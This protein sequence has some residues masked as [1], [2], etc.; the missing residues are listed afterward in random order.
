MATWY[1]D[2]AAAPG[3]TGS[4]SFPF[5]S[6]ADLRTAG[7]AASDTI[8]LTGTFRGGN[9]WFTFTSPAGLTIQ[10]WPNR[11][12]PMI[13][14][15]ILIPQTAWTTTA[16]PE[17]FTK[18]IGI[19]LTIDSVVEDWDTQF[20][21]PDGGK[22][23]WQI[24]RH[25]GHMRS[26]T[27][28]T[29]V[30][31]GFN[32]N[33]ATGVLT[34]RARDSID[35]NANPTAHQ[36]AYCER[37]QEP[38]NASVI[39][40]TG[41]AGARLTA[42]RGL[43]FALWPNVN[44]YNIRLSSLEASLIEDCAT[45]DFG[46]FHAMGFAGATL[47]TCRI[48]NCIARG[49]NTSGAATNAFVIA[50]T[51]ET[52]SN[53]SNDNAIS[54]CTFH[55]YGLLD[56]AG[57]LLPASWSAG[58]T[59]F[60]ISHTGG[61]ATI[62]R[63]I[64]SNSIMVADYSEST[65]VTHDMTFLDLQNQDP[66]TVPADPTIPAQF[67]IRLERCEYHAHGTA[68]IANST[69]VFAGRCKFDLTDSIVN[70]TSGTNHFR[71]LLAGQSLHFQACTIIWNSDGS[72]S[73]RLF[74]L[75]SATADIAFV[76]CTLYN[77]GTVALNFRM[78]FTRQDSVGDDGCGIFARQSVFV[79]LVGGVNVPMFYTRDDGAGGPAAAFANYNFDSCW[80]EYVT[81]AEIGGPNDLLDSVAEWT[82][83]LDPDDA[84]SAPVYNVLP[85]F[86][87][88]AGADLAPLPGGNLITTIFPLL[89][90]AGII[91]INGN[92]YDGHYG[93]YQFGTRGGWA[94]TPGLESALGFDD[95]HDP[96]PLR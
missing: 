66:G 16:D 47:G 31:G 34:V 54:G 26:G 5:D 75:Q 56:T 92:P 70:T 78:V 95:D 94:T 58:A 65:I 46:G 87:N 83:A 79:I 12:R 24:N 53:P 20:K 13:R 64:L 69:A 3:G 80:Y 21:S 77:L 48:V 73:G 28:G 32:Y 74:D 27:V 62:G 36:Y 23:A 88:P 6:I 50:K 10:Q 85:Q 18:N 44:S 30:A 45:W 96:T 11:S 19:G 59:A 8:N 82:A 4:E 76:L 7:V 72:S 84:P 14:G 15:D 38:T 40:M 2:S 55:C 93:A 67:G 43:D 68:V 41:T 57:A 42:I 63:L 1:V 33:V 86:V 81:S 60:C 89:S 71:A 91:G 22:G 51:N 25:M 90:L 29:L 52:D 37:S 61:T 39:A 9:E 17:E 35:L 49:H